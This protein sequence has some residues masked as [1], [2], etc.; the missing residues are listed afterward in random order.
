MLLL[1]VGVVLWG[2]QTDKG[3]QTFGA[4]LDK[5]L[6]VG[7]FGEGESQAEM[8]AAADLEKAQ[9]FVTKEGDKVVT[10][11]Q[12]SDNKKPSDET[13]K[14]IA[15]LTRLQT[16]ILSNVVISDYQLAYI[17]KLDRLTNLAIN[18]TPISDA[19][20][21]HL[22]GLRKLNTL[23]MGDVKISDK[24]LEQIAELPELAIL[25]LSNTNITDSGMRQ[26][27][28][29]QNLNRLIIGGTKVT[30]E[31]LA[32]L[33]PNAKNLSRI[34]LTKDMK[35]SPQGIEK[36]KKQLPNLTTVDLEE[37]GK[38]SVNPADDGVPA[39]TEPATNQA[40]K[41]TDDK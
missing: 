37:P 27:S 3:L 11:L 39:A 24:G 16:L 36:L 21:K 1:V 17:R 41:K 31:G 12:F 6:Y 32:E 13:L 7:L 2:S 22:A 29:L 23:Y 28:K 40:E 4:I 30:D 15:Q 26:I 14:K 38:A 33:A 20:M 18:G 9:V 34:G 5:G 10:C 8:D 35:I 25:D 19:G